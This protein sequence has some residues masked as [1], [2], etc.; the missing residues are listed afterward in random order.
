L[1]S[2]VTLDGGTLA[3]E[4]LAN[5]SLLHLNSGTFHLLGELHIDPVIGPLGGSVDLGPNTTLKGDLGIKNTGLL[6]GDGTLVGEFSNDNGTVRVEAGK[7][8]NVTGGA[9]HANNGDLQLLG[10]RIDFSGDFDNETL[11]FISGRGTLAVEDTWTNDGTAA[12]SAGF[13]DVFGDVDNSATGTIIA[14]GGAT[15]TFYGDVVHNG[16]EIRTAANSS[17]V[18]LG[19]VAGAG[20]FTGTGTNYFEGDLQPGN[21]AA[22]VS[23]AGDVVFGALS[24]LTIELGGT[25]PGSEF[26]VLEIAGTASLG[27]DLEVAYLGAFAANLGDTFEIVTAD[28]GISGQFFDESLP[29]LGG[30]LAWRV[31]Y[32]SDAVSMVVVLPGDYNFDGI[33]D[34]ADYTVW[35]N[36]L[37]QSGPGLA[38]DGD[39]DNEITVADYGI[40]KTSYGNSAGSGG[41][42][43]AGTSSPEPSANV[44]ALLGLIG[45]SAVY[46]CR[47]NSEKSCLSA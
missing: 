9:I 1:Q 37:G 32:D 34:A 39:G 18:F 8:L 6:T 28:G 27:G 11:G 42:A 2:T 24:E 17:T 47:I 40:W 33:V 16:A 29:V 5:P 7:S 15:V 20:P 13:T 12:F 30:N 43:T 35:R 23:V 38:A 46:R 3:V 36:T 25:T 26:D 4:D 44:L 45:L 19:G 22:A 10:G 41:A 14:T 21:S 31:I